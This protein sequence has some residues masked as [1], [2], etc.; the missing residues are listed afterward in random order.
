MKFLLL[1]Y[2]HSL[3]FKYKNTDSEFYLLSDLEFQQLEK[4]IKYHVFL[5]AF[6]GGLMV[7]LLYIPQYSFPSYFPEKNYFL[8]VIGEF[9]FNLN[10]FLFGLIL[11]FIELLILGL[12]SM[13]LIHK[14]SDI[15]GYMSDKEHKIKNNQYKSIGL[16]KK[17]K[18]QKSYGIY[19][20]QGLPVWIVFSYNL[21]IVLKAT[22]SNMVFKIL[23]KRIL[24]RYA[25]R[26]I[27][28][29][30]G[31]PIFAFWNAYA[32]YNVAKQA[33]LFVLGQGLIH[34]YNKQLPDNISDNEK[35]II[36][37]TL[38]Y[39]A[40]SKRDYHYNHAVL[41]ELLIK[42]YGISTEKLHLLPKDYL[43][44]IS[45][46]KED[47]IIRLK[48]LILMGYILDGNLSQKEIKEI[49]KLNTNNKLS[50]EIDEVKNHLNEFVRGKVVKFYHQ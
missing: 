10:A 46:L 44:K 8:P 37:D 32:T 14:I 6:I 41:T 49:E 7:V 38:Q 48:N 31:I 12:I 2:Y 11:I 21:F 34:Q 42:K 20:F 3:K 26:E 43:N 24:G 50:I 36:Y 5:S 13:S 17:E 40:I 22:L 45:L 29:L 15:T 30:S 47:E 39:I 1:K 18:S 23:V 27:L 28:D 19:P 35:T 25:L 33:K 4:S 16:E 9:K